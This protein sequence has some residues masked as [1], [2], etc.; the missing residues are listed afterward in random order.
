MSLGNDD[1]IL[2]LLT[3]EAVR[4]RCHELL[5]MAAADELDHFQYHADNMGVAT[6]LVVDEITSN[7]PGGK[8][9]F[10]SRWRHFE[11]GERDLWAEL[12]SHL[13]DISSAEKARRRIDLAVVSVLLDAG[14]GPDWTY[15][16]TATGLVY[17]RSEGLALASIRLVESGLLSRY[18]KDDPIRVDAEALEKLSPN[19]LAEMFQVRSDNPLVGLD[20]RADLLN[21]LGSALSMA[22]SLFSH[23]G[24]T[25]PGHLYDYLA[26]LQ[27]NGALK[28]RGIL[29]A[30]LEGLGPIWPEGERI[31]DI[32]LGDVG[33]HKKIVRQDVSN[34]LLP[35]HKLSQWLAYSLI[36]PLQ[37][38][39]ITITELDTLTGLAEYRNGGL[40][41]DT[42]VL[43]LRQNEAAAM[44]HH[45][46]S[47]LVVEWRGL[48]VALLDKVAAAVRQQTGDDAE[49]LPLASVLQGGTWTAGRRIAKQ[50][51]AGGGP[52]LTLDISGTIF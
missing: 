42:K 25:R 20:A 17:G 47:P 11:F 33:H 23:N 38:A 52:P 32:L 2:A 6:E 29:I 45:P 16:D 18:G 34:G 19:Q 30:L 48:T 40:F 50:L 26:S 13:P 27:Q 5:E 46:K 22:P 28:A 3:P 15:K 8:V 39:G 10:H 37:E 24:E 49:S 14:A 21:R 41:M 4:Q 36:E 44:S 35:F 43:T 9:P 7:Y 12:A 51:R 1:A 31:G